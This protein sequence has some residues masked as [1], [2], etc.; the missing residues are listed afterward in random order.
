ML[1]NNK[2]F[3]ISGILYPIFIL[4]L[5]FILGILG[6]LGTNKINLDR[7]KKEI[8]MELNGENLDPY[9]VVVGSDIDVQAG[10]AFD[11]LDGI[12]AYDYTDKL[13]GDEQIDAVSIPTFNYSALGNYVVSYQVSDN[14]GRTTEMTR[15][16]HVTALAAKPFAYNGLP[17]NTTLSAGTYKV[18]LWGAQGG[19]DGYQPLSGKGA[20]TAGNITINASTKIDILVGQSGNST[21]TAKFNGGGYGGLPAGSL[22]G[23]GATDIR[24]ADTNKYRYIRNYINGSTANTRN[25]WVE[26]E[27]YDITGVNVALNKTVTSSVEPDPLRPNSWVTDGNKDTANWTSHNS[28][29]QWVEIDLGAEY[30]IGYVKVWHYYGDART[31]YASKTIMYD[32]IRGNAFT[33]FDSAWAGVYPESAA[34]LTSN[35]TDW[36][37]Y[38]AIKRRIMVAGAG[39]GTATGQYNSSGVGSNS[40]GLTGQDG[41]YYAGHGDVSQYGKGGT[42]IAGGIAGL[43][44]YSGTGTNSPGRFGIG[45]NSDS[46]SSSIGSGGGGGGYYGGGAGGATG[47]AGAGNGAGGGSSFISGFTGCNAIGAEGVHT[48]QPNHYSGLV[49]TNAQM[50]GGTSTMPDPISGTQTGNDGDGYA[51]ITPLVIVNY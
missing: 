49:F 26:I 2:G 20:Y 45:G 29:L 22:S 25:H 39:G 51:K 35:V 42:Q 9:F 19:N 48:G 41:S 44:I 15:N 30:E 16:I 50:I 3:A 5:V 10:Y 7:I 11:L 36:N 13:L 27:V 46:T 43:N 18:E 33:I 12:T 34:G 8:E 14:S 4:F 6:I 47:S 32:T 31:Y 38:D 37:I 1:L 23:G 17:Q 28:G 40:L 24:V 21:R